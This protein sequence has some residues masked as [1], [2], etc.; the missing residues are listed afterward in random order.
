V[1]VLGQPSPGGHLKGRVAVVTGAAGGLGQAICAALASAGAAVAA[2]DR[3]SEALDDLDQRLSAGGARLATVTADVSDPDSV[4]RMGTE[5]NRQLGP[6]DILFNNAAIYPRRPWTEVPF[7]EWDE[8]MAVN[9]KGCFLCARA[10]GEGLRA[11]PHGRII[12]ISSITFLKGSEQLAAYVS[13][14]G[15]VIG[16]TRALARELGPEGVTVNAIAPGA[17]PTDAEKIHPDPEEY[18]RLVL[19]QQCIK[20]RGRGEDVGRLVAFLAGDCASFISG[21]T[22]VIDGG[23]ALH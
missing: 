17:F 20:R 13:S 19:E 2:V 16:L 8:V 1:S 12:N 9:A 22:I 10:L 5:V 14:K 21:Q 7:S 18:N 23:W 6:A 4:T 11:S 15:A 3:R